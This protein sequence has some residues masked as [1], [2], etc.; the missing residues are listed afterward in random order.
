MKTKNHKCFITKEFTL[1]ELLVVIAIIAILAAMLLPALGKAREKAKMI[2]CASNLKQMF[3]ISNLY[4][5]DNDEYFPSY[6]VPPMDGGAGAE[7]Y[8]RYLAKYLVGHVINRWPVNEAVPKVMYCESMA[9]PT[10]SF[11]TY[12]MNGTLIY[13][14]GMKI[15]RIKRSSEMLLWTEPNYTAAL[16]EYG[17][18]IAASS[19]MLRARHGKYFNVGFVDGHVSKLDF[20]GLNVTGTGLPV[21]DYIYGAKAPF[22]AYLDDA[23]HLV[24]W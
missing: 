5:E 7:Y 6:V 1:I 4:V 16:Y 12:G 3:H 24:E 13:T 20:N 2:L 8:T 21:S 9:A 10:Y 11:Q 17:H 23:P 18:Y 19:T 22:F 14:K 15:T